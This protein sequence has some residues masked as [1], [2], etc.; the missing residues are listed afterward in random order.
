M[1]LTR[2]GVRDLS[3]VG[4]DLNNRGEAP[5]ALSYETVYEAMSEAGTCPYCKR[6]MSPEG[7]A[8]CNMWWCEKCR[9]AEPEIGSFRL[10]GDVELPACNC[11]K[12][13]KRSKAF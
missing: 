8:V 11:K 1:T 5:N 12:C 4:R 13:I 6:S 7:G 3:P 10:S 2:Q 9:H